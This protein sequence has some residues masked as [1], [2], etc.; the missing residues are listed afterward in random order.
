ML[1]KSYNAGE[2]A[3][4][5]AQTAKTKVSTWICDC[6]QENLAS[7]KNCINCYKEKRIV[8]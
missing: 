7:A 8:D 5:S 4:N 6:G 3:N 2:K 1:L